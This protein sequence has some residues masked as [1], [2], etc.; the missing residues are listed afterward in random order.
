[1][2]DDVQDG[3]EVKQNGPT[4]THI[5]CRASKW[6]FEPNEVQ[7]Y[8]ESKLKGRV[9]N[10][11]SGPTNLRHNGEIVRNDIDETVDA[12]FHFDALEVDKYFDPNS[13]DTVILDPPFSFRKSHDY[14]E[15]RTV[16]NLT[17]VKD[18]VAELIK[19]GGWILTFGYHTRG[20]G[21]SRGYSR[22]EIVLLDH[23]GG[24]RATIGVVEQRVER[25]L[26]EYK[27]ER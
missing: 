10:L 19:P 20:L 23:Y 7:K 18:K 13:F 6:T 12:D 5:E 9:L 26:N 17:I 16:E 21:Q 11:F 2:D 25:K 1:M 4:L 24:V 22:E 3:A 8:V 15:G 14:Y 27:N